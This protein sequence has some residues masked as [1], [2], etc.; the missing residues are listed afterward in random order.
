MSDRFKVVVTGIVTNQG[1][2]LTGKKEDRDSPVS[3]EWHLP[4]VSLEEGEEVREAVKK[5]VE[6]KTGLE[7]NVHQ[8][9]DTY[10]DI[11]VGV[12]RTV[13]HCESDTEEAEAEED[14]E[15]VEWVDPSELGQELGETENKTLLEREE[16]EKF[17]EKLEQMPVF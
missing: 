17:I 9:V 14:L 16:V 13:F 10:Y 12:V 4:S 7:I 5:G 11:E 6:E 15:E 3:G 8:L 1:E 2:I